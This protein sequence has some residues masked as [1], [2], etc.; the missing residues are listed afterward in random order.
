MRARLR[1][2][3]C[4]RLRAPTGCVRGC[5]MPS[6]GALT[7]PRL[8]HGIQRASGSNDGCKLQHPGCCSTAGSQPTTWPEREVGGR[9]PGI[10]SL[11]AGGGSVRPGLLRA[12]VKCTPD[13]IRT[14]DDGKRGGASKSAATSESRL[15]VDSWSRLATHAPAPWSRSGWRARR[16]H[17]SHGLAHEPRFLQYS[18]GGAQQMCVWWQCRSNY[19]ARRFGNS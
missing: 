14:N 19:S 17:G 7:Q 13:P 10:E 1:H 12:V 18:A 15:E 11:D 6:Y 2:R 4:W 8:T 3:E 5:S 16:I 9:T